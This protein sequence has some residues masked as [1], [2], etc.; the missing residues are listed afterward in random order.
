ML[1]I[2]ALGCCAARA[3]TPKPSFGEVRLSPA[4]I[5]AEKITTTKL[6]P[7][8]FTPTRQIFVRALDIT[9]LIALR[10]RLAKAE[11]DATAA[12]ANSTNLIAR[13]NRDF[14]LFN[15][16]Q[17]VSVQALQDSK[18]ASV[19]AGAL[20]ASTTARVEMIRATIIQQ[21]GQELATN[22]ANLMALQHGDKQLVS[23]IFPNSFKGAIPTD[24]RLAAIDGSMVTSHLIG[25]GRAVDPLMNGRPFYYVAPASLPA[26]FVTSAQL[27][28][29][30]TSRALLIPMRAVLWYAGARWAYVE[31]QPGLF[32]RRQVAA[33]ILA[34]QYLAGTDFQAGDNLVTGGAQLLLSQ[35]LLPHAI[36]TSCKD[37]PE[38]DD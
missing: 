29:A 20:V 11:A 4:Q 31:L 14:G 28:L 1:S 21:Y 5:A 19:A 26:G 24:I 30:S 6:Q 17:T 8:P 35:E 22:R 38:C 10:E 32:Q 15:A 13:Y 33:R 37:P 3:S 18:A 36:A 2:F 12:E 23:V 27:P 9:P 7:V 25:P 16:H 34:G